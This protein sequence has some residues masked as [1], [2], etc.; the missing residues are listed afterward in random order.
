M[1]LFLEALSVCH[2]VQ[3]D[4]INK[5]NYNAASP[6]E[7]CFINFCKKYLCNPLIFSVFTPLM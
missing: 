4:P 7:L 6:D 5:E 3:I 2:N 1:K